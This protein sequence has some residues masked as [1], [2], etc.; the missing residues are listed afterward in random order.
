VV[1]GYN[2]AVVCGRCEEKFG[3][4]QF[5]DDMQCCSRLAVEVNV[6]SQ[7]PPGNFSQVVWTVLI[8]IWRL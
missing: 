2:M 1:G 7:R 3:E 4:G 6:L 5:P 8:Y